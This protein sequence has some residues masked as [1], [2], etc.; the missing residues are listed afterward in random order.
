MR[1]VLAGMVSV[2]TAFA[3]VLSLGFWIHGR[4]NAIP[5]SLFGFLAAVAI[6]VISGW[7]MCL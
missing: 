2:G 7:I 5:D 6:A 1:M 4:T 3:V